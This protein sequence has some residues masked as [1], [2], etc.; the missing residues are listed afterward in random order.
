MSLIWPLVRRCLFH[1]RRIATVDDQRSMRYFELLGGALHM[2]RTVE[3]AT[4][5]PH[6][7]I[8]LP[9]SGA[10]PVALLGTWL[11]GRVAV[12][13]NYLLSQEELAYVIDNAGLDTIITAG[14][15]LEHLG[16]DHV[17]EEVSLIRMEELSFGGLPPLRWP[18]SP[19]PDELAVL[20]YTSGTSGRPKGV[21][22]T[23]GNLA[24]NV[25]GAAEHAGM[26]HEQVFLGVLPQFHS[27]GLTALTLLPLYLGAKAV[28]TARFVPRRLIKLIEKHEP[29]V[30]MAIPSMYGAL[31]GVKKAGAESLESIDI[32]VSGGEALPEAVYENFQEKYGVKILEGYGLTETSPMLNWSTPDDSRHKSVG[33]ALP[34]VTIMIVNEDLKPLGT[35]EEGEI[36]AAGPNIMAGYYNLPEQT[37]E[38]IT[39]LHDPADGE[40]KRFFRT[41]DMGKLDEDGFLYITG[42]IKEMLIVGGENVF[43]REIEEVLNR[44]DTVAASG[45]VGRHDDT[46]GEVPVAFV[47]LVEDAEFDENELRS[48]CRESLAGYKVPRE[49]RVVDEL[50]R[51]PTGKIL[52]RELSERLDDDED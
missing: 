22:L 9:T 46:R 18:P 24:S 50:P 19:R 41:G 32:A 7:G 38:V 27:F 26:T 34:D 51:N 11:A 45:V 47:E 49:I 5:N 10:F 17:P 16:E 48:H 14:A 13:L 43:P 23:H 20:L 42:R 36:L 25:Q 37:D 6:V 40:L 2:A 1:P 39:F 15:M 30:F 31:L 12:P 3:K 21:M 35:E 28:Y 29:D 4:D 44:H 8:M 33:K 52:R